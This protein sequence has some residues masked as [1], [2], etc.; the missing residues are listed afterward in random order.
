MATLLHISEIVLL[1]TV[2]I[3]MH[4]VKFKIDFYD[5]KR[6][7]DN[8]KKLKKILSISHRKLCY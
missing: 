3:L 6:F 2:N 7:A 5:I 4:N 1:S 8:T